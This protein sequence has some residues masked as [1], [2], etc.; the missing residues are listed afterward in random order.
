MKVSPDSTGD[1]NLYHSREAMSVPG[2]VY[3]C[4]YVVCADVGTV[5]PKAEFMSE[6]P[7]PCFSASWRDRA[8]SC[9]ATEY[10]DV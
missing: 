4:I 9:L 3:L 2:E 1:D 10:L 7:R 6:V 8:G 5:S